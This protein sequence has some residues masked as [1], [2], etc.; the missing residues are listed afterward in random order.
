[1]VGHVFI[2]IFVRERYYGKVSYSIG[3]RERGA[4]EGG[5]G[6]KGGLFFHGILL[7]QTRLGSEIPSAPMASVKRYIRLKKLDLL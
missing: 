4:G 3:E 2:F 7:G 5:G 1:M 6:G